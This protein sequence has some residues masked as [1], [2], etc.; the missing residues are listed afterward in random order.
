[1]SSSY[2]RRLNLLSFGYSRSHSISNEIMELILLW[3]KCKPY[4]EFEQICHSPR[5]QMEIRLDSFTFN[6]LSSNPSNLINQYEI[7]YIPY[8]NKQLNIKKFID[9]NKSLIKQINCHNIYYKTN[10]ISFIE[11]DK[12]GNEFGND[13]LLKIIGKNNNKN[14]SKIFC[15]TKWI[16]FKIGF[17]FLRIANHELSNK[18][19]YAQYFEENI[20]LQFKEYLTLKQWLKFCK[21]QQIEVNIMDQKRCFHFMEYLS[22]KR[23]LK[24]KQQGNGL[25]NDEENDNE[26]GVDMEDFVNFLCNDYYNMYLNKFKL[27]IDKF[28]EKIAESPSDIDDDYIFVYT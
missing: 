13:Y 25:L 18:R 23:K 9:L 12:I 16:Q 27:I 3:V 7:K 22:I 21:N 10:Y 4:L 28:K 14:K 20:D 2:K 6:L 19:H 15:E 1:M 5:F 17:P 26:E 24:E 8:N 11:I